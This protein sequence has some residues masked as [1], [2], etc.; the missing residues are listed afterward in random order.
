MIP[1]PDPPEIRGFQSEIMETRR[2]G[3]N[4]LPRGASA[5]PLPQLRP[6]A[7]KT[8]GYSA[9]GPYDESGLAPRSARTIL[10]SAE[11]SFVGGQ[12]LAE[13]CQRPGQEPG[14]VH[15]GDA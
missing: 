3:H 5:G 10:S 7:G 12:A 2:A 11:H 15:L 13:L 8:T 6:P 1:D 14:Y 9:T 4:G